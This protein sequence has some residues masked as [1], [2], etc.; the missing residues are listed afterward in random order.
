M[1]FFWRQIEEAT[2][3]TV[4]LAIQRLPKVKAIPVVKP[5]LPQVVAAANQDG[6]P[7]VA[8][9]RGKNGILAS[10]E[11]LGLLGG[12]E[13]L[14]VSGQTVLVKPNF[15]SPH[16]YP[17]TTDPV[18]L[19]WLIQSLK[20]A[21]AQRVLV[22]ESSGAPWWPTRKVLQKLGIF[23]MVGKAGGELVIFEEDNRWVRVATGGRYFP[24]V[25]LPR[26]VFEVD[27]VIYLSL[28][29]S[30]RYAQLSGSLKLAVGLLHPAQRKYLHLSHL[31][32]KI[33]D[34]NRGFTPDLVIADCRK[35]FLTHGPTQGTI[36]EPEL[37]LASANQVALDWE[38]V[39]Q[40][41]KSPDQFRTLTYAVAAGLGPPTGAY[42]VVTSD[43]Q[44]VVHKLV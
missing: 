18:L 39:R 16:P 9:V 1:K 8:L 43:A 30:H 34:I 3:G 28:M 40:L 15:N 2:L 22:G 5:R 24:Q 33:V 6:L 10:A 25:I 23:E 20:Q 32:E 14:K 26:I 38:G 44:P 36:I 29:K 4:N 12:L 42:Q 7:L 37:I 31:K 11:A 21:G 27:R 35:T 13:Q 41:Q 17:A 19:L